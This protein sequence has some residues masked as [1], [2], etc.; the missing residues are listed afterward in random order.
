MGMNGTSKFKLQ[1]KN[2]NPHLNG[3]T[4]M[5]NLTGCL[6]HSGLLDGVFCF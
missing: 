6:Y 5:V 1:F 3:L 4:A 2:N